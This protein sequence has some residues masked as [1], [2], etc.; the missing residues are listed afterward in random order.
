[1]K[2]QILATKD[3]M[4]IRDLYP[5]LVSNRRLYI[6]G[7]GNKKFKSVKTQKIIELDKI[8]AVRYQMGKNKTYRMLGILFLILGLISAG[9]IG[10]IYY[11]QK[12]LFDQ[13]LVP[14]II[15][16]GTM[17]FL[18]IV[19]FIVYAAVTSRVL[20]IE[21]PTNLENKPT[22]IVFKSVKNKEF[23]SFISSLFEA[24]DGTQGRKPVTPIE[25]PN[26]IL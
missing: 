13:T 14:L 19:F 25:K 26:I 11:F 21:Y 18:S 6:V 15:L 23:I 10:L 2:E 16:G 3:E 8:S 1:M 24:I 7:G 4:V 22:R 9:A 17:A 12:E 20:Y 5:L